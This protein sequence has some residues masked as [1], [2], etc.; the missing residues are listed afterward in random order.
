MARK[1]DEI[2]LRIIQS[3]EDMAAVEEL[4]DQIWPGDNPIP[5]HMLIAVVHNGGMLAGA[6]DRDRLVGY[7]FGFLGI[8]ETDEGIKVKHCSH[9]LG[10]HPDYQNLGI[11]FRLK[12]AQWQ[13]VRQQGLDLITWTYDPLESRNAYLNLAKLGVVCNTYSRNEYGEMKDALN[14][15]IPSDRFMVH[16]WINS[17][18]VAQR[19]SRESRK[20][21]DL[22]HFLAAGVEVINSTS[23]NE[24]GLPVPVEDRMDLIENPESQVAM[25]LFEIPANYQAMKVMDIELARK[26][27]LYSRTIFELFFHYGYL[28]T[29]FV[30]L[31]GKNPRAYYVLSQGD[32]TLGE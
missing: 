22:A 29:D 12:R 7:I 17:K 14:V 21:L 3:P 11:G 15:G 10:V 20:K 9:Q 26:W 28:V 2:E 18:R 25:T 27:R 6:Y 16:W 5:Y 23:L 4:E 31:P 8:Y 1:Q 13:L 30:F 24:V 19:L 32:I